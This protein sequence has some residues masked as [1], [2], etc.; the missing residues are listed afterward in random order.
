VR[1]IGYF[2]PA[3]QALHEHTLPSSY[4]HWSFGS[5][6]AVPGAAGISGHAAGFEGT[7]QPSLGAVSDQA[8][9]LQTA[10]VRHSG[11]GSSPQLQSAVL[12]PSTLPFAEPGAQALPALGGVAAQE[13]LVTPPEAAVPPPAIPPAFVPACEPPSPPTS[14]LLAPPQAAS[15]TETAKRSGLASRMRRQ[16]SAC[17]THSAFQIQGLRVHLPF[18]ADRVEN[19]R[20]AAATSATE[21]SPRSCRAR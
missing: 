12:K 18:I 10:R 13:E 16:L 4:Q 21:G 17:S 8:P 14:C 2:A 19:A 6:Q 1:Q 15:R 20:N 9:L 3:S 7:E 5:V 11:R